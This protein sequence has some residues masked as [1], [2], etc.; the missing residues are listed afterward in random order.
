MKSYMPA[1][2]LCALL[3]ACS[4]KTQPA[5][6]SAPTPEAAPTIEAQAKAE[7]AQDTQA[8]EKTNKVEPSVPEAAK[9]EPSEPAKA[10]SPRI[11]FPQIDAHLQAD[12]SVKDNHG[13]LIE[14]YYA[15]NADEAGK[16]EKIE[17]QLIEA[18]FT[19]TS[20][21]YIDNYEKVLGD[22]VVM[23]KIEEGEGDL[24]IGMFRTRDPQNRYSN[25]DPR[26]PYPLEHGFAAEFADQSVDKST[27]I[28]TY[29]NRDP[30]FLS[31]YEK[32]LLDAGFNKVRDDESPL[33][34]KQSP[35]KT[36]FSVAVVKLNEK[37]SS[38]RIALT[39]IAPNIE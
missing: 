25:A 20:D 30:E 18:G 13:N 38:L 34:H 37:G 1:L 3:T 32:H 21:G 7:A 2:F 39:A 29:F 5:E 11:E 28:Y 26:I 12:S 17:A 16:R 8:N 24:M 9:A 6:P 35:D 4:P 15:A 33:Y 23:I 27:V 14:V 19:K 22:Q 31:N 10:E 36:E